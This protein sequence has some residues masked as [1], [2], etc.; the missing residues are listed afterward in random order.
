MFKTLFYLSFMGLLF[1]ACKTNESSQDKQSFQNDVINEI[2]HEETTVNDVFID[3]SLNA[4]VNICA[5]IT[6]S[7]PY[8]NWIKETNEFQSFSQ[9]FD[10]KWSTYSSSRLQKLNTFR[11]NEIEP[12]IKQQHTLFYPFSG[13][14][15]L[16]AQTFFPKAER[17]VLLGLEPV[18]SL[19]EFTTETDFKSY[20]GK[21]N[22]S[23]H[24]I[25]NFSFFRTNSMNNDLRNEDV[26][27]VLHLLTLF[28]KRQGNSLHSVK[29][30]YIDQSGEIIYLANFKELK[31][32]K[33]PETP[34][35]E[36]RF[37]DMDGHHKSLYYY[38]LNASDG[39]LATNPGFVTYMNS[40]GEVNTYLKGA[41]YL[42]HKAYFSKVR[43]AILAQSQHV[44]QDDSGIANR[45]F[46][47]DKNEWDFKLFGQYTKPINLFKNH[48]QKDL[49]SLYQSQGAQKIGFGIGYNFLDKNSNFMVITKK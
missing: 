49:D 9:N 41:T 10:E 11:S 2:E 4:L 44:V 35:V 23:L 21:V 42:M 37:E 24:A 25:L 39:A 40:L 6:D 22:S 15:I 32:K 3:D 1:A 8:F 26:D 19:P 16:Y 47:K 30:I 31:T 13:P 43:N 17:Y 5:G 27:G 48:Y 34:G 28:L 29:P 33:E 14:D 12:I 20:Y 18:G 36:I 45:Y 46:T 7:S 38:S